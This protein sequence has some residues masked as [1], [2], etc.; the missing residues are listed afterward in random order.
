MISARTDN[1]GF[2]NDLN[3]IGLRILVRYRVLKHMAMNCQGLPVL[4]TD[5]IPGVKILAGSKIE[6]PMDE[7]ILVEHIYG[8]PGVF[9]FMIQNVRV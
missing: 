5:P 9:Q 6:W 4:L 7:R 2:V 3:A 1:M 8:F